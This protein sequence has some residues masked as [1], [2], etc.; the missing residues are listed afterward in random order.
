M[1]IQDLA[2]IS[3]IIIIPISL[4]L[5]V[6]TQYQIQTLNT[7][8]L[9]DTKLTTATFDA[10]KAF[11]INTANSTMS[12]LS[13]SKLR[14]IEASVST[15]KNS[16]MSTF[17]LKG[18]TEED[19]NNFIPA[20]V[21]TMYD[22]FYIYSPY[23]NTNYLYE[24][25]TK[26]DGTKDYKLDGNGDKIP[27]DNNGETIYGLKPY[28][29]YS[30]RYQKNDIDVIITYSLDN[31]I[32]IQGRKGGN[33]VNEEGYL[34]DGIEIKP[35]GTVLYNDVEIE[36]ETL[37]ED[38]NSVPYKY[39]KINGTKY[40]YGEN[41]ENQDGSKGAIFYLSNGKATI[42]GNTIT[43]KTRGEVARDYYEK[44]ISNNDAAIK[45]YKEADKFTDWVR[46]NLGELT[47]GDAY[48]LVYSEDTNQWNWK[49]IQTE[50]QTTEWA[51]KKIFDNNVN[52]ENDLSNFNLHRLEVIR[53]K[54]E[55]NLS[56]AIAN[57]NKYSLATG[58]EF[59]LPKLKEEEWDL[60]INNISLI[61]FVQGLDIGGKVYNGYTIV[62]NSETKEVVQEE[63][64]YILGTDSAYHRIGDKDLEGVTN[65][66]SDTTDI[67]AKSA[68]RLNLDFE[69]Q[70]ILSADGTTTRYYYPLR[71]Y[72]G[73]YNSIV[74]QNEVTAFDD[75]YA[76]I[77]KQKDNGNI[78][79]AK[80]FYTA[81]GRERYGMYKA[82]RTNML[83]TDIQ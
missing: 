28:I 15:F 33:Y 22:G 59:Q 25:E 38:I 43:G 50:N 3:V 74:T 78:K 8:T 45:Y 79:L 63:N 52:I 76:Y 57:Y 31:Y 30:C 73:S 81:L 68:G 13:N 29:T 72:L 47:Y 4:V 41:I 64:I 1:K 23:E 51:N 48:D 61:S 16:I 60:L 58:I 53:N 24:M 34:I 20:L 9:Y 40:Y 14:D 69:K 10:I 5:S 2:I 11:Q 35:D 71:N 36:K 62:T 7:Q 83:Y 18:Y 42:Q 19:M 80:A 21:Y 26:A 65:K 66:I 54:I 46:D 67:P 82:L 44:Y 12:D 39:V 37:E 6:Y 70:K 56:I 75:I 32:T 49:K 77:Q 27:L 17:G 55:S